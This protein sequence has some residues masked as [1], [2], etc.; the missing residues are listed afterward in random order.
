M[1]C[2]ERMVS[3]ALLAR[4]SVWAAVDMIPPKTSLPAEAGR[5]CWCRA[6]GLRRLVAFLGALRPAGGLG[7]IVLG[8]LFQHRPH[9]I[10]HGRDP[11]GDLDPLGAV[12]LLHER[13]AMT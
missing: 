7:D 2:T 11:I 8:G 13:R 6:R 5:G 3:G 10:L 1:L 12:P 9:L 4:G